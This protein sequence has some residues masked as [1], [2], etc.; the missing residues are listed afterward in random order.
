MLIDSVLFAEIINL[1]VRFVGAEVARF[2]IKSFVV[3]VQLMSGRFHINSR[4]CISRQKKCLYFF[5]IYS[6]KYIITSTE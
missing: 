1:N 4:F 3:F 6:R 2:K 5:I